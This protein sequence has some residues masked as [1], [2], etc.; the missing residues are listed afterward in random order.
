MEK[1]QVYVDCE[2]DTLTKKQ[3][4]IAF[5]ISTKAPA[6]EL[7]KIHA[8]F[9][10]FAEYKDLKTLHELVVPEISKFEQRIINF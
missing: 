8:Q 5:T 2:I 7:T 9:Q 6:E 1:L 4:D 3:Q 10:R